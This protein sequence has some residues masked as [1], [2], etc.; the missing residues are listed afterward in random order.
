VL[1]VVAA[2]TAVHL[3]YEERTAVP[4][5]AAARWFADQATW[6][7]SVDRDGNAVAVTSLVGA[8]GLD[9]VGTL[10]FPMEVAI[11]SEV[12]DHP[13]SALWTAV[14][15]ARYSNGNSINVPEIYLASDE[16]LTQLVGVATIVLPVSFDPPILALPADME[17]GDSWSQ[18]GNAVYG[19]LQLYDYAVESEVIDIDD[20]GCV[21]VRS[22]TSYAATAEAEDFGAG[23]YEDTVETTVCPG[24]WVTAYTS[25][26]G[27][28]KAVSAA[29]ARR[30]AAGFE[31]SAPE[32]VPAATGR[33]RSVLQERDAA[34]GGAADTIVVPEAATVIDAD[35]VTHTVSGLVWTRPLSVPRWRLVGAGPT[36]ATPVRHRSTVVL[37]DTHGLVT[38]LDASSGFV[39]W[40][41]SVGTL[42]QTLALDVHGRYV[43]V[44]DRSGSAELLTLADGE[45]VTTVDAGDDPV[46]ISVLT[47]DGRPVLT[48][49]DASS[50]RGYDA[51]G[52]ELFSIDE[53]PSSG[54]ALAGDHAYVGTSDGRV[55]A[56]DAEGATR[57]THLGPAIVTDVV[58]GSDALAVLADDHLRLLDLDDLTVTATVEDDADALSVGR[59]GET[60]TFTTTAH[61]G[62]ITTYASDL[63]ELRTVRAPLRSEVGRRDVETVQ[64]A[65]AVS[66]DGV[67][68]ASAVTGLVRWEA[69]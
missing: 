2:S 43:A 17:E 19:A 26:A 29:T 62:R 9:P 39:L 10:P 45:S 24:R 68:W 4:T 49:A 27:T 65:A 32:T 42:P 23:D 53:M 69:P 40:Q 13:G 20:D 14:T 30:V 35:L 37:A 18:E 1:A 47:D 8:R 5:P 52:E 59:D 31:P 44:L 36:V 46:G 58:A 34:S 15:T 3:R 25:S 21:T 51:E 41:A 63:S 54:L 55:V 11:R 66:W 67:V 64:R 12:V 60:D 61:D 7:S 6:A 50:V 16:G 38:A 28:T 48:I 33:R 22:T 57:E 56:L